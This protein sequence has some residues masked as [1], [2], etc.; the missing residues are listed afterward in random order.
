MP[1][2]A[3]IKHYKWWGKGMLNYFIYCTNSKI[4]S[5]LQFYKKEFLYIANLTKLKNR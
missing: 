2:N 4:F 3:D 5:R 1:L